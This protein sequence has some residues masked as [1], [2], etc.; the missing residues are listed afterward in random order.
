MK[1]GYILIDCKGL[2]LLSQSAQTVTGLYARL[3]E[4]FKLGKPILACNCNYGEGVPMTP[5]SVMVIDE[6]GTYIAT[7]SIL[8]ILVSSDDSVVIR[9]LLTLANDN[10]T[11]TKSVKK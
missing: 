7:S 5:I 3:S 6:G 1:G 9:N 10:R 4:A 11:A 2:N 8:Q